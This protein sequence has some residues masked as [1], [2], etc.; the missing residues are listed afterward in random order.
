MPKLN[1]EVSKIKG[2]GIYV[3]R[4]IDNLKQMKCE[5]EALGC[6]VQIKVEGTELAGNGTRTRDILLGKNSV[7]IEGESDS[8]SEPEGQ[9][10]K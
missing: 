8:T 9:V 6:K 1:M 7:M 3:Q 2:Q 5:L 4:V 10:V